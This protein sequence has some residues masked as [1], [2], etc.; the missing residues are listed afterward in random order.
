MD[1]VRSKLNKEQFEL[2]F[3]SVMLFAGVALL[4]VGGIAMAS[5]SILFVENVLKLVKN[6]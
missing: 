2:L 6:F 5:G 1:Y 3:R 4:G